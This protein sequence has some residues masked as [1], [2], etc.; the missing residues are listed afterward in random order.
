LEIRQIKELAITLITD[1]DSLALRGYHK[2]F[3]DLQVLKHVRT[4]KGGVVGCVHRLFQNP[5]SN[6]ARKQGSIDKD[7]GSEMET[8]EPHFE[9]HSLENLHGLWNWDLNTYVMEFAATMH[10]QL[11]TRIHTQFCMH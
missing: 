4:E 3:P 8:E 2:N 10:L 11:K 7:H 9:V 1:C 6:K 5:S